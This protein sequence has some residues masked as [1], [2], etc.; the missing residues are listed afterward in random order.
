MKTS[1]QVQ[2]IGGQYRGKKIN[3][4]DIVGLRPTPNRVKE[5]LFNWLMHDIRGARCLDAFAGSGSLGF[6]ALSR[7]ASQVDMIESALPAFRALQKN[8]ESFH[9]PVLRIMH[10]NAYHY[11]ETLTEPY[12]IIFLDPPFA[13]DYIQQCLF[14]LTH[15]NCLKKNGILYVESPELVNPDS[16][17]WTIRRSKKAGQVFYALFEKR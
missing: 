10:D 15:N 14:I 5:T 6:E 17:Q 2:I 1:P 13:E 3:F 4:P 7:G 16:N 11:L 12:D 9:S 8:A